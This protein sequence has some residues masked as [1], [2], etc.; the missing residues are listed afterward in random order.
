MR[1]IC[2]VEL[3]DVY[4]RQV[5]RLAKRDAPERQRLLSNVQVMLPDDPEGDD[6]KQFL[7]WQQN[8]LPGIL[9]LDPEGNADRINYLT[10]GQKR[11]EIRLLAIAYQE[12]LS[13]IHI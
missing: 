11:A 12:K 10:G 7:Q 2:W 4:K 6:W 13:L 1:S 9:A 3:P 5:R 8:S